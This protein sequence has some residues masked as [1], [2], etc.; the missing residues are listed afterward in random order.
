MTFFHKCAKLPSLNLFVP[1][2]A[3]NTFNSTG[4]G[5]MSPKK[6]KRTRPECRS[7][8]LWEIT[9]FFRLPFKTNSYSHSITA[10]ILCQT[11]TLIHSCMYVSWATQWGAGAI[12]AN[13]ANQ[14][15]WFTNHWLFS[16]NRNQENHKVLESESENLV[17][18]SELE[19][20]IFSK[21]ESKF[22]GW[23][24]NQNGIRLLNLPGIGIKMYLESCITGANLCFSMK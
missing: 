2:H 4:T 21:Q 3:L 10:L 23:N 20:G 8:I 12:W 14:W 16:W 17:L 9:W 19:S 1:L 13:S 22:W 18:E 11:T 15:N 6:C 24:P 7:S 5:M